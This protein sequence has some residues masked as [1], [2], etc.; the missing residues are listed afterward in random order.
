METIE[1]SG[2]TIES[3]IRDYCKEFRIKE[4]E[5]RYDII[6]RPSS[7]FL[8]FI[9]KRK[10]K[11]RFHQEELSER[12]RSFV[13]KLLSEM[14]VGFSQL[15]A[16]RE[17]KSVYVDVVGC[18]DPGFLIGKNGNMLETI[19][20]LANRV[21]ESDRSLERVYVDLDG[22]RERK[23]AQFLRQYMTQIRLVEK[24][25]KAVTLP[26]MS[27][28]DRRV[29]HRYIESH[30]GLKTLTVGEGE[31]KRVVVF[32]AKLSE[33]DALR[34]AKNEDKPKTEEKTKAEGRTIEAEESPK[35][36]PKILKPLKPNTNVAP[37]KNVKAPKPASKPEKS[38]KPEESQA[39]EKPQIKKRPRRKAPVKKTSGE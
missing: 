4:W 10:A 1:R 9:G 30:K 25:G 15:K 11:L 3:V 21:F 32:H 19:Q 5:L 8:G 23:E 31:K 26:L 36:P 33:K 7:G 17:N 34:H 29:I 18:N 16:R 22:Y 6:S 2:E 27:P 28:A 37:A 14:G 24:N 12:I 38:I 35:A 20:F 13:E 39:Q